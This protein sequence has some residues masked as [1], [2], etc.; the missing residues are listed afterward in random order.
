MNNHLFPDWETFLTVF[1]AQGGVFEAHPPSDSVT[2]L[3][4]SILIEPD[5]TAH[6]ISSGDHIHS[7]SEYSCWGLS[8]PQTSVD[9]VVLN[10]ECSKIISACKERKI[11]GYID[12]DFVTF[13]DAKSVS[14]FNILGH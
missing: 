14:I 11:I 13:I 2:A 10:A 4:V 9:P 3:T 12:I 8:F 5:Q 1:I 6:I 7:D